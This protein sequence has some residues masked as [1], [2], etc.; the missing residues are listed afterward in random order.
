M[1]TTTAASAAT[2]AATSSAAAGAASSVGSAAAKAATGAAAK[3]GGGGLGKAI[4]IASGGVWE[5]LEHPL[6]GPEAPIPDVPQAAMSAGT[7]F[8]KVKAMGTGAMEFG[9][10]YVGERVENR[11]K[12]FRGFKSTGSKLMGGDVRGFGRDIARAT[13]PRTGKFDPVRLYDNQQEEGAVEGNISFLNQVIQAAE[14]R[15]AE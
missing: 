4:N 5:K 14:R 11:F 15:L 1:T 7:M 6:T 12:A 3:A 13:N 8:D 2:G 9:K 10:G